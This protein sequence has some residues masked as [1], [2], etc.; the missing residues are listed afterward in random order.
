MHT[1][2]DKAKV[3]DKNRPE[4]GLH[5]GTDSAPTQIAIINY[6]CYTLSTICAIT[7]YAAC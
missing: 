2:E 5:P 6:H 4:T 7:Q 3:G 1:Q